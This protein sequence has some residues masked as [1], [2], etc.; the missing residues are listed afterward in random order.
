MSTYGDPLSNPEPVAPTGP[1]PPTGGGSAGGGGGATPPAEWQQRPSGEGQG[2]LEG[3]PTTSRGVAFV[4]R[5]PAA[6]TAKIVIAK[7]GRKAGGSALSA[8]K[9]RRVGTVRVKLKKGR[10][11]VRVKRVKRR[12]LARGSYRATITPKV[13]PKALAPLKVKFRIRR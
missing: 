10:N 8:A 11:V 5:M 3:T 2:L 1:A 6:G 9:F 13:G 7:A 4:V 12:K